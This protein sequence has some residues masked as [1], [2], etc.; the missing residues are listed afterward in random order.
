[1]HNIIK[2]TLSKSTGEFLYTISGH[3]SQ[4]CIHMASTNALHTIY[5]LHGLGACLPF[6][7]YSAL[8]YWESSWH[9]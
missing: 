6:S 7:L 4:I 3:F 8:F 9:L 5:A 2:L 1:M